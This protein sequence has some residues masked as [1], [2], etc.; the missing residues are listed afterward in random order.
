[1]KRDSQKGSIIAQKL[2]SAFRAGGIHGQTAMPEDII[3]EG[4]DQGSREH[5]LFITLTVAIDYQRDAVALWN[6]SRATYENPSTRYLFEPGEL[7]RKPFDHVVRDMQKY[8][9]SRK[10]VKDARIWT[11]IA[12]TFFKKYN[13]DPRNLLTACNYKADRLLQELEKGCHRGAQGQ[14]ADFPYLRGPKI[15]PLWVR[16]LRDN[17]GCDL[18]NMET[19]PIPV[20]IHVARATLCLGVVSGRYAGSVENLFGSIRSAWFESVEGLT[21]PDGLPFTALDIDEPLW[22]LSRQGCSN[23]NESGAC[24]KKELC[25]CRDYCVPGLIEINTKKGHVKFVTGKGAS[26]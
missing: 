4:I 12:A 21:R 24:P 25:L 17:V 23:R 8:K 2:Y 19:I 6:S 13:C 9:L 18:I 10:P 3:P 11:T 22:H 5:L 7:Y 14:Q 1:M 16:M 20:D 15:G 26:H